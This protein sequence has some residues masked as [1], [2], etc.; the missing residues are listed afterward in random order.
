MSNEPKVQENSESDALVSIGQVCGVCRWPTAPGVICGVPVYATAARGTLP[1]FCGAPGQAH[2]Q[3]QW[4]TPGNPDHV[5]ERAGYARKLA[6][7]SAGE[8]KA[9]AETRAR[10]LHIHHR[11]PR[12]PVAPAESVPAQAEPAEQSA[13]AAEVSEQ[14][15]VVPATVGGEYEQLD[16]LA[17]ILNGA[18]DLVAAF[19]GRLDAM[20]ADYEHRI[21]QEAARARAAVDAESATRQEIATLRE[22]SGRAVQQAQADVESARA[23]AVTA[24]D[25]QLRAEGRLEDA[26]ERIARLETELAEIRDGQRAEIE[27]VRREA[28]EQAE[29]MIDAA[30]RAQTRERVEAISRRQEGEPPESAIDEM[31][32]RVRAGRVYRSGGTWFTGPNEQATHG[33]VRTLDWM[34]EQRMIVLASGDPARATLTQ[35]RR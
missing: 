1:K 19:R 8:A 10:E 9:L 4:K 32:G 16:R 17:E 15:P 14:A 2:W 7:M 27:R 29:R 3:E 26:R 34:L 30:L 21:D 22:E 31:S 25:A 20:R 35:K 6:G 13:S 28:A 11:A 18:G 24:R 33:A 5:A 23:E 12:P